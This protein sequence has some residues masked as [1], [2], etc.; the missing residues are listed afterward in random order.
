MI[1]YLAFTCFTLRIVCLTIPHLSIATI[2][3][4]SIGMIHMILHV[5]R[6]ILCISL[7]Y[8]AM[9]FADRD[10]CV[11]CTAAEGCVPFVVLA[12]H[13]WPEFASCGTLF[14]CLNCFGLVPT[15]P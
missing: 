9:Y 13:L 7:V 4:M 11:V 1:G 12:C 8:F 15:N 3:V 2:A 5:L 10:V 14:Y 6:S